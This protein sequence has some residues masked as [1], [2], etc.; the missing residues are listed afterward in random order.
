MNDASGGN[1]AESAGN[2]VDDS[3]GGDDDD[4]EDSG[5][6]FFSGMVRKASELGDEALRGLSASRSSFFI[7]EGEG[8]LLVGKGEK[9][10]GGRR[11]EQ[12]KDRAV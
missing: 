2:A 10:S 7:G 6:Y 5:M 3:A 9:E 4:E 12:E 1:N 8:L 11:E